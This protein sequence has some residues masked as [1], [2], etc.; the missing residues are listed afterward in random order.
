[1]A[2]TSSMTRT[3][4]TTLALLVGALVFTG[5]ISREPAGADHLPANKTAAAGS[6]TQVVAPGENVTLLSATIRSSNPTDLILQVTAECSI[7]TNVT[8]IG[9]DNQRAF[10]QVR[11]WVEIDGSPVPVATADASGGRVVFCNRAYQRTTE[12]LDDEDATIRTFFSTRH[13]NAFN[14][15][16]LDVGSGI[17]T[18][19]VKGEL[20]AEATDRAVAEAVIGNRSL[21][22]EPTKLPNDATVD[23]VA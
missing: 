3:S 22:V 23:E 20:T 17:H 7:V 9:N 6:T 5:L 11:V 21:I 19:E 14:W 13:A 16:K 10:G 12:L 1:M 2:L 8:T 4:R 15:L 18:I